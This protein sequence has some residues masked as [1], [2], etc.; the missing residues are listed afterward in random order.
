ML[1]VYNNTPIV[2]FSIWNMNSQIQKTLRA[3]VLYSSIH[4]TIMVC[5]YTM[6]FHVLREPHFPSFIP[7]IASLKP[8]ANVVTIHL[9]D[10]QAKWALTSALF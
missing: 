3:E 10:F 9:H 4:N 2:F 1:H 5:V 6:G 7:I 8:Y